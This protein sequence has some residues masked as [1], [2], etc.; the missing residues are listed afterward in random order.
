MKSPYISR[1]A[2]NNFRNFKN[3]DVYLEHKQVIVGENSVGKTN[4]I[5][6]LQI[7]LDPSL[8]GRQRMLN[9]SDFHDKIKDPIKN[10]EGI[11]IIVEI[12]N[13]EH[14]KNILAQLEDG[15]VK[16]NDGKETIRLTYKFRPIPGKANKYEYIIY[17][18]NK[19]DHYNGRF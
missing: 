16:N 7:I 11:T 17:K 12:D 4:Y 3:C 8:S 13:Y 5:F 15:V 2:I 9:E 14:N 18:G 10:K 6:A 1:V 19:I